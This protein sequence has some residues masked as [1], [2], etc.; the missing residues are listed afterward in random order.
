MTDSCYLIEYRML[1]G[2]WNQL[3]APIHSLSDARLCLAHTRA[4]YPNL[5]FRLVQRTTTTELVDE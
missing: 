5:F 2:T 1:D 3:S 4:Q